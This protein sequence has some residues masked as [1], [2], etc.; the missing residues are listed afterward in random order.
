MCSGR[1]KTTAQWMRDFV[2]EH[3]SYKH[4]SVVSEQVCY[5]LVS[6]CAEVTV[7]MRDEPTLV[8]S[9][10]TRTATNLPTAMQRNDQ[11]LADMAAKRTAVVND[12]VGVSD[13]RATVVNDGI[14][15]A[16]HHAAM[17]ND[18]IGEVDHHATMVSD[19]IGEASKR[20]AV[21]NSVANDGIGDGPWPQTSN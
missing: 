12:G 9:H 21:V 17:V 19:G 2:A 5:D 6:A 3:P 20:A 4:D 18:G 1:L 10:K 14:S 13:K 7:G 15:E 16:D 8:F 11:H